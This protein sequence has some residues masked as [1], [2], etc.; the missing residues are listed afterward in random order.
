MAIDEKTKGALGLF[1]AN[2]VLGVAAAALGFMS[3]K[4]ASDR[5]NKQ[6]QAME[7]DVLTQLGLAVTQAKTQFGQQ[8]TEAQRVLKDIAS[9]GDLAIGRLQVAVGSSG[10]TGNIVDRQESLVG[11]EVSKVTERVSEDLETQ[12]IMTD[13]GI[14]QA[15]LQAFG[16]I[17]DI[18][19]EKKTETQILID[20]VTAGLGF[21]TQGLELQDKLSTIVP[22]KYG[23]KQ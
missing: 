20:A 18:R 8:E 15:E 23:G 11:S 12:K 1:A 4:K 14:Q 21:A 19:A 9:Q 17:E 16:K 2:P 7:N 3:S 6:L 22:K 5:R 13:L 10:I